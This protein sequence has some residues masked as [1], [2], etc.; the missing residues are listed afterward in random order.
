M[1]RKVP[2]PLS[3]SLILILGLEFSGTHEAQ[4]ASITVPNFSFETP[5]T[6]GQVVTNNWVQVN[7]PTT[8]PDAY[9]P[10]QNEGGNAFY[11]GANPVTDPASGGTGYPGIV[12]ENLG[13]IFAQV[14]GTQPGTGLMQT[15]SATLQPGMQYTLTVA[16]GNRNGTV[17]GG[18]L[19]SEIILVAGTTVIASATDTGGP[20]A[21][22][23]KDEVAT[24]ANSSAFPSLIGQPLVIELLTTNAGTSNGTV[25][26]ATDWDNVRL[27][28]TS[29]PEPA[30]LVLLA[31]A[32]GAGAGAGVCWA[33]AARVLAK[34]R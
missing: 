20:A 19:G 10:Y 33:R 12:G 34:R 29:V 25:G 11:T 4:A 26:P 1:P 13:F 22:S 18:F 7:E 8:T 3:V 31:T 27:T 5:A 28:A 6:T 2:R 21:G 16:E 30:S 9:N 23:F 15:L 24:L 14:G 17:M 32:L